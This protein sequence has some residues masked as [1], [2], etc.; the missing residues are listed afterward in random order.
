MHKSVDWLQPI[1]SWRCSFSLHWQDEQPQLKT[2]ACSAAPKVGGPDRRDGGLRFFAKMPKNRGSNPMR[3]GMRRSLWLVK[4][5]CFDR[6]IHFC[7]RLFQLIRP[8]ILTLY[9]YTPL[10]RHSHLLHKPIG[11]F[12]RLLQYIPD[13]CWKSSTARGILH[14]VRSGTAR[15]GSTSL[16]KLSGRKARYAAWAFACGN[17]PVHCR[18][19]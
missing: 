1:S 3:V 9:S 6:P 19:P 4:W 18:L 10:S 11:R 2:K 8:Y 17:N 7:E 14:Y 5:P 13:A 12:L 16:L 15:A